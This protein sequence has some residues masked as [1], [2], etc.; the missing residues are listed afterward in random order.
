MHEALEFGVKALNGGIF[1]VGFALVGKLLR[2]KRFSGLF[3]AAP[4]VAVGSIASMLFFEGHSR[5]VADARGMVVG[6]LVFAAACLIGARLIRRY[7]AL[8]GSVALCATWLLIAGAAWAA[9]AAG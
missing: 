3:S 5:A 4:S 1:V 7:G 9:I 6:G 8:R 2:P